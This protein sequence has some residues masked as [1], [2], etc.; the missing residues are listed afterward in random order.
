MSEFETGG[1]S[2]GDGFDDGRRSRDTPTESSS[3]RRWRRCENDGNLTAVR[4]RQ[5]ASRRDED[6]RESKA[7]MVWREVVCA[8]LR[9]R[10]TDTASSRARAASSVRN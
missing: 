2:T 9:R 4:A 7:E 1:S 3:A 6:G 5:M 8:W 10:A